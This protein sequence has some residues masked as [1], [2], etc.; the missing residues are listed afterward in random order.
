MKKSSQ[1]FC[2]SNGP[3]EFT[4]CNPQL[5]L[6]D[7]R[8]GDISLLERNRSLDTARSTVI[9]YE[10]ARKYAGLQRDTV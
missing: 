9:H 1:E 6:T 4:R 8:I 5:H 10:S 7:S 2:N 3:G